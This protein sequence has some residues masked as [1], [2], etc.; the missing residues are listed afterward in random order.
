MNLDTVRERLYSPR[1][2]P[3]LVL[4]LVM[5]VAYVFYNLG[6]SGNLRW[7]KSLMGLAVLGTI[8]VA[9]LSSAIG[10]FLLVSV[11]PAYIVTGPTNFVLVF[12][13]FMAWM[14]RVSRGALERP[15]RTPCDL[16][17][18]LMT[19]AYLVSWLN[20]E[21]GPNQMT[22]AWWYT[23]NHLGALMIFYMTFAAV[24]RERDIRTFTTFMQVLAAIVYAVAF[25]EVVTGQSLTA[26]GGIREVRYTIA[27]RLVRVG[28]L[29]GS[30]DLTA[31]FCSMN[32]PL[33]I[34][35]FLRSRRGVARLALGVLMILS[36]VVLFLTSNRGGMVGLAVA[37]GYL[38]FLFR[39]DLGVTA[40]AG[41]ATGATLLFVAVDAILSQAGRTLSV[42]TRLA[43]TRFYGVLPETRVGVWQYFKSRIGEH[44]WLG[45]GPFYRLR[46]RIPG[47]YVF[48][49]HN[50][51]GYYWATIGI[52]G[53][54]GFAWLMVQLIRKTWQERA[55]RW[56]DGYL[57]EMMLILHVMLVVFLVTQQRTDFQRGFVFTYQAFFLFGLSMGVWRLARQERIAIEEEI[58]AENGASADREDS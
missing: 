17:L 48:W 14:L 29:L 42:F 22:Q 21:R 56:G 53:M 32:L 18:L 41:A 2:Y 52:L 3:A 25:M 39:K 28:G 24:R 1:V 4:V 16:P 46:P 13:L 55:A 27:G 38:A 31:D 5:A 35:L 7:I 45:E 43:H 40:L 8:V 20:V 58:S 47:E 33:H 19:V 15:S 51:F 6:Y 12:G 50:A 57:P 30:H 44:F 9:P 11:F 49:P 37:L 36:V 23:Q 34:Y 26:L 10:V 54:V